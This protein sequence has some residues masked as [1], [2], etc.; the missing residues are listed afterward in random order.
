M[1]RSTADY[2]A[3]RQC[4]RQ[5]QDFLGALGAELADQ[6]PLESLRLL[7]YRTG[8][9]FATQHLLDPA[10]SVG[11]MQTG[12]NAVWA[13]MD[14]GVTTLEEVDAALVIMHRCSPLIAGF[15]AGMQS[16]TPAF[17][18]GVY[19]QWFA[20]LGSSEI[21]R[22]KQTSEPDVFGTIEYRLAKH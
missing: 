11:D 21:L 4:V 19:Q 9:R 8:T 6:L 22:V 15:G 2:L 20:Q 1:D 16:W 5:W 13:D 10:E 7:F 14:W 17:L 18:E 12:M 3:Q